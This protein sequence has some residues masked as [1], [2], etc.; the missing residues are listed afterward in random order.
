MENAMSDLTIRESELV[1][2]GAALGG[3]CVPCIEYHIPQAR[4]AG[5]T[6]QEIHAAILLADKV[7]QVPV[8][9]VLEAA[10]SLLPHLAESPEDVGETSDCMTAMMSGMRSSCGRPASSVEN[11]NT[12]SNA[13][14]APVPEGGRGCC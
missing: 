13:S 14:E 8:R 12:S 2:L 7:R 9:K 11:Q 3:N 6:D 1:A 5:L 4:K 10:R